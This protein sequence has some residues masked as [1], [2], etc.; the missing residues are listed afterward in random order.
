MKFL[1]KIE[2]A[3]NNLLMFVFN[4][5]T[6]LI[7]FFVYDFF[8]FLKR[9]PFL[10]IAT[11]KEKIIPKL[12][13]SAIKLVGYFQ[14][15]LHSFFGIFGGVFSYLRSDE[16][17]QANK[18][19]LLLIP[20]RFAKGH[21]WI[22]SVEV[23]TMALV[24][25]GLNLVFINTNKILD[26]TKTLRHPASVASEEEN[27]IVEFNKKKF[28]VEVGAAGGHG[29]GEGHEAELVLDIKIEASDFKERE[30]IEK[31]EENLMEV[32]EDVEL[33]VAQIPL[34]ADN[35]KQIEE[36]IYKALD[37][38]LREHAH[39]KAI[40]SVHIK[41][42]PPGRPAY[43]GK[44]DRIYSLK[45]VNLQIFLDETHRNRQVYFDFSLIASNRNVVNFLRDN[46]VE[47]RDRLN[48]NIEPII[49]RLL[50]DDEGRLIIKDKVK[51]EVNE[52]LEEEDVEGKIQEIYI[53]SSISS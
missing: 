53:D 2:D 27:T 24:I 29:G 38:D 20:V 17:K 7:P 23:F 43:Y 28:E 33:P 51:D 1:E 45:D 41:Q 21:P 16:F 15:Y 32:L 19:D 18:V 48:T 30:Y 11:L 44:T 37:E 9:L 3:I 31:M 36:L 50:M 42:I 35:Q 25:Y 8:G 14:H 52:F 5:L 6:G 40:K 34:T 13:L 26:G 49:H 22:A 46:E 39:E 10:I 47:L 12:K 4:K